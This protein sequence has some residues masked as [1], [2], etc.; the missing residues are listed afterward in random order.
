MGPIAARMEGGASGGRLEK[1]H[2]LRTRASGLDQRWKIG[3]SPSGK[4][5]NKQ[6]VAV[7]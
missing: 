5:R 2:R 6:F 3:K 4:A 1:G 7:A